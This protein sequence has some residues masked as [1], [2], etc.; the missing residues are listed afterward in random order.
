MA[1]RQNLRSLHFHKVCGGSIKLL[2]KDKVAHRTDSF[3]NGL[4]F[5]DRPVMVD[6]VV[7]LKIVETARNWS[8]A[9]RLGFTKNDPKSMK[10]IPQHS[11]PDFI[12]LPGNWAK[13]LPESLNKKDSLISFYV[14]SQGDVYYQHNDGKE[15]LLLAKVDI[16]HK[17]WGVIDVYGNTVKVKLVSNPFKEESLSDFDLT[18]H[19]VHGVHVQLDD[20][21]TIAT[22]KNGM[23]NAYVF[24][25]K[26]MH[27]DEKVVIK[28]LTLDPWI[29]GLFEYGLT[30]SDP[31]TIE[32]N[33]LPKNGADLIDL[34]SDY[35]VLKRDTCCYDRDDIVTFMLKTDGV[36]IVTRNA[37]AVSSKL[38]VD[39]SRPLWLFFKLSGAIVK[40]CLMGSSEKE[41]ADLIKEFNEITTFPVEKKPKRRV[42]RELSIGE[43]VICCDN[44]VNCTLYRCGHMCMCYECANFMRN[45][46]D[47]C[48]VCRTSIEDVIRVYT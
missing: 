44:L 8:G 3:N 15:T 23:S 22:R 7:F 14:N 16:K 37:N 27:F 30:S 17:L 20:S 46:S 1:V 11:C 35:W 9:F 2:E 42:S 4:T 40:I 32:V 45:K 10:T 26:P 29:K 21:K 41:Y 25:G 31:S 48:P 43:C 47:N 38:H 36:F 6:E 24:S 12:S 34:P 33:S 28:I 13:A 18:F 39:T 19:A 5:T